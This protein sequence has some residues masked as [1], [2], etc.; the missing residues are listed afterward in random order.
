MKKKPYSRVL[1][2]YKY[3]RTR[4]TDKTIC[5]DIMLILAKLYKNNNTYHIFCCNTVVFACSITARSQC[6]LFALGAKYL[7]LPSNIR[8]CPRIQ[9]PVSAQ[10]SER[11]YVEVQ[12]KSYFNQINTFQNIGIK[13]K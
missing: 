7:Y 12:G 13:F 3:V 10:R 9:L 1:R 6:W 8:I 2:A 5:H 4:N 11:L